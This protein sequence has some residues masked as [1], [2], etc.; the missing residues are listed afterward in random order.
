MSMIPAPLLTGSQGSTCI[1]EGES[2]L[3]GLRV[4]E[5]NNL[6]RQYTPKYC[7]I[8]L[9]HNCDS[10]IPISFLGSIIIL[11]QINHNS[12]NIKSYYND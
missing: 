11:S 8:C 6:E 12:C 4:S 2:R 5:R 7:S 1:S 3:P 9:A 10:S